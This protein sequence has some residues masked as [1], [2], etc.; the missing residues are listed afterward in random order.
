MCCLYLHIQQVLSGK[1]RRGAVDPPQHP[2]NPHGGRGGGFTF[3]TAHGQRYTFNPFG[4][5]HHHRSNKIFDKVLPGSSKQPYLLP[6]S[7]R[8]VQLTNEHLVSF[9]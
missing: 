9:V 3:H 1:R 6:L 2:Y 7:S 4:H 5:H 8:I